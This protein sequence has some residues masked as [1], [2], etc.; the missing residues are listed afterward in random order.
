MREICRD[1]KVT[2]PSNSSIEKNGMVYISAWAGAHP[3]PLQAYADMYA[4]LGYGSI[5]FGVNLNKIKGFNSLASGSHLFLFSG[6][7]LKKA[8]N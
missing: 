6:A 2:R 1:I 8:L 3:K 7:T 4:G 5:Q